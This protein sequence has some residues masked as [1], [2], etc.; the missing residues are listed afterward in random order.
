MFRIGTLG[1]ASFLTMSAMSFAQTPVEH[2]R[3]LV[4][5]QRQER[6]SHAGISREPRRH[7]YCAAVD[8]LAGAAAAMS[9]QNISAL[10]IISCSPK[11]CQR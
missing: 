3:Y 5:G 6:G 4:E 11:V 10:K 7:D 9:F 2:G 1:L 8:G